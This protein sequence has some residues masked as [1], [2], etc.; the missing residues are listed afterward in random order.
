MREINV[1]IVKNKVYELC[2][3]LAF[4]INEDVYL[5]L[6][7]ARDEEETPL[8]LEVLNN[9]ILNSQKAEENTIPMCQDTG[10]VTVYLHVGQEVIFTNG[11]INEYINA[12]IREAY[13]D[14][15]LRKSIVKDPLNRDNTKDNTPAI[16]YYD[17]VPGDKVNIS[18]MAKGFGSEN[19][20]KTK[21]L[22]PSMGRAGI[23][24][25]V[26]ETVKEAGSNP[27][28]PIVIGVGIGGSLDKSTLLAK[29]ALFREIGSK[30]HDPYYR[31]LENEI[32]GKINTLNIG[33]MGFGGKTTALSV[34]IEKYPTHIAGLPVAV[35]ICCHALRRKVEVI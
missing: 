32:L 28:P 13:G 16:I 12:G 8:S 19:M 18:V 21:M 1:E 29:E 27:C 30:N 25:F 24:D 9:L 17:I 11:D 6:K 33:P 15:F 20:S 7:K 31:D 14:F 2:K 35:N 23:V 10:L 26:V 34:M 22:K 5:A 4:S 3:E